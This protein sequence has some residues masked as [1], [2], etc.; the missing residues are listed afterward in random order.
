MHVMPLESCPNSCF[1]RKYRAGTL[2][3]SSSLRKRSRV[4]DLFTTDCS[5]KQ[6]AMQLSRQANRV[7]LN[8]SCPK[9]LTAF[10]TALSGTIA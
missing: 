9:F 5:G 10:K 4:K 2:C 7:D 3:R 8:R 1:R 6:G